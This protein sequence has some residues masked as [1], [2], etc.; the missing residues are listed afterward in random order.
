MPAGMVDNEGAVMAKGSSRRSSTVLS[1]LI[2]LAVAAAVAALFVAAAASAAPKPFAV[3]IQ[4]GGQAGPEIAG[5]LAVWTDN[6]NGNLDIYGRNVSTHRNY[7]VCTN[8]AQQDNP[9]VTQW[10]TGGE[11]HYVA[12]WV[13]KRNHASGEATDIY[14]RD[15]TGRQNF[16]VARSAT[17]KWFPEIVDRWVIWIEADDSAGPYRVKVR[18]LDAK[19]T[20]TIATSSVLSP[21]GIDSRTVGSKTVYTAVYTSGEGNISGRNVPDGTP[22]TVSQR[23]TFE[24]MPDISHNRVVW[25]ESGGR[26]M[27]KNL[28]TGKRTYVH[29]GSRPRID[30]ELVTWD[31]GGHGGEF[32]TSY[33]KNAKIYVRNIARSSSVVA[34]SQKDLTCL[35]PA[36]SGHVVVWES[37]PA[38]RVLSHIHIYAAR[39]Q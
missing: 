18:D 32:T 37:G 1:R 31:G 17:I 34:I 26:V 14:G 16:V 20:T 35:F 27:L 11:T 5:N 29:Q 33:L 36:I 24:W 9:S 15:I 7:A 12:V 22:F 13:D 30:G 21:V 3:C 4:M 38:R 23:S 6:R 10:S 8:H 2:V 25:W 19:Q 28:S 39:L